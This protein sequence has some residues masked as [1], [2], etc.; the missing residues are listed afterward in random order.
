MVRYALFWKI[1]TQKVP[2]KYVMIGVGAGLKPG[3]VLEGFILPARDWTKIP[4]S[5]SVTW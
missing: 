2:G 4:G 3:F 1:C 5:P